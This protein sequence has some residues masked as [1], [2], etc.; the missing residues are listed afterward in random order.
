[1]RPRVEKVYT[2]CKAASGYLVYH[3]SWLNV[4]RC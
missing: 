4:T 2:L 3:S 1:M